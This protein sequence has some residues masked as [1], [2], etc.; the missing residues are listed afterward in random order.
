MKI[1]GKYNGIDIIY[2]FN[3]AVRCTRLS[4]SLSLF[5]LISNKDY[6]AF[7]QRA[8]LLSFK[9]ERR[10]IVRGKQSENKATI[11]NKKANK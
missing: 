1:T 9:E 11:K 5:F 2:L 10:T 3:I 4:L 7:A 6:F 8:S